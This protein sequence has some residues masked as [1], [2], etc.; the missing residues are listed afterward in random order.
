MSANKL[1][2]VRIDSDVLEFID[3]NCPFQGGTSRSDVI[4]WALRMAVE[5]KKIHG[6]WLGRNFLHVRNDKVTK[7]DVQIERGSMW[8]R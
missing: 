7:F 5:Y 2:S 4:N 1:I 3:S 8:G 6:R